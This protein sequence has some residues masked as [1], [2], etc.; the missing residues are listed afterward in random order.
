MSMF[1]ILTR[2][3]SKR[4]FDFS[5]INYARQLLSLQAVVKYLR[6]ENKRLKSATVMKGAAELFN[7]VDPLMR[8]AHRKAYHMMQPESERAIAT[9]AAEVKKLRSDVNRSFAA[10]EI[11]DLGQIP[12]NATGWS[13]RKHAP[14]HQ[15]KARA[16]LLGTLSDRV[17]ESGEKVRHLGESLLSSRFL[18]ISTRKGNGKSGSRELGR[19][20]VKMGRVCLPPSSEVENSAAS[21]NRIVAFKSLA[22]FSKLHSVFVG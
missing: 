8:R 12:A 16:G 18:E 10:A 19:D 17:A 4:F 13:L 15:M 6:A 9:V 20:H 14:E 2:Y 5:Y 3:W 22:E 11:V 21:R 7:P 1:W